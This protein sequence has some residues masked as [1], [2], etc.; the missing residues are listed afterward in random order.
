M[1]GISD[2][3]D[4]YFA[5]KMDAFSKFG[6]VLDSVS[7]L[8]FISIAL[9]IFIPMINLPWRIVYWITVIAAVRLILIIPGLVRYQ[10]LAFLRTYAN[11]A[12]G[13]VLF[14][15]PFLFSVF[16]KE[17]TAAVI[18]GIA[19]VSEAEEL[20]INLISKTLRRDRNSIFSR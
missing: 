5:R 12:T 6:Q 18:C 7:D 11:K 15:F 9:L 8:I 17:T 2:D 16:G 4:E 13:I 19:S 20:L 3:L 10:Q 1:C 14:C